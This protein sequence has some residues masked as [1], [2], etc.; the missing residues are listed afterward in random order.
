MRRGALVLAGVLQALCFAPG[1]LPTALLAVVQIVSLGVLARLTLTAP[2]VRRAALDGGLFALVTYAVGLYWLYI[3]LHVYGYMAAPLAAGGVLALAA[4]LA[5]YPAAACALARWLTVRP[6]AATPGRPPGAV[7]WLRHTATWAATWTAFEWLRGV[8]MSGFP[9]LNIAYGHVDSPLAGWAPLFGAY[10]LAFAAAFVAAAVALLVA[11]GLAWR[12]RALTL[13]VAGALLVVGGVVALIGWSS[14]AG[15]PLAVR[16]VQGNVPQSQKFEPALMKQGIIKHMRLAAQPASAGKPA[17]DFV[18]LPETVLPVFQDQLPPNTWEI[19]RSLA[20]RTNATFAMG[21]PLHRQDADGQSIYT[22]SVV[23]F[24][25]N[26]TAESLETATVDRLYDK[27]HLVP[28]GEYVPTGFRWFVNAMQIPLGDFNRGPERQ[29]PFAVRDQH[30]AF[31]I[32]YEDL[33]GDELLP[34]IRTGADGAPGATILA[35]VS[36]LGWFG[37]SWALRQHLQ[38]G[39]LRTI[40]TARPMLAATNTGL[41]ALIDARGRV[42]DSIPSHTSGV[43]EVSVQGMKGLTPYTRWGD[44]PALLIVG[45]M[46]VAGMSWRMR[47]R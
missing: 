43:L 11:N 38:I 9:W 21:V 1:P 18:L 15:N 33:F 19:W 36:N 47:R 26:T 3:S 46:L 23:A 30:I 27:R 28:F 7:T 44:G 16:L 32:C 45:L 12:Q 41:T 5:L 31:N 22:N 17:P 34:A 13:G 39:R 40:E 20:A 4:Y 35:N 14:P 42:T 25:G 2:S 10:G 24:D 8:I 6:A 29:T 37:D